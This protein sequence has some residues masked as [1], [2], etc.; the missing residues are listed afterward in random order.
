MQF[1]RSSATLH[2]YQNDLMHTYAPSLKQTYHHKLG[3]RVG[4]IRT[5]WKILAPLK[6][7]S[8][9]DSPFH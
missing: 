4:T 7:N 8:K 9:V 1:I 2:F 3:V 6:F 5:N